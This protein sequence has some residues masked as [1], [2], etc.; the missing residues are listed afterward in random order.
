MGRLGDL[1]GDVKLKSESEV[2][3]M[4]EVNAISFLLVLPAREVTT[5]LL[6]L[7]PSLKS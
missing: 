3:V 2:E 1:S 5:L 6:S 4:M 7:A